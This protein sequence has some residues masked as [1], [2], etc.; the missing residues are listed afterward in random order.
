MGYWT[1]SGGIV[2]YK[3]VTGGYWRV[4]GFTAGYWWILR[5]T[6]RYPVVLKAL[7]CTNVTGISNGTGS[8]SV[9]LDGAEWYVIVQYDN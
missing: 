2:K 9:T 7:K 4:L 1:M 5:G 6:G 3:G 8:Y